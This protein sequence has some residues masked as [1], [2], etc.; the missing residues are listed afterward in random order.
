[1]AGAAGS[2]IVGAGKDVAPLGGVSMTIGKRKG[3]DYDVHDGA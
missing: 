1:M 2:W 3:S